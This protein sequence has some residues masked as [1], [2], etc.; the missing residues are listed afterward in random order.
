MV[1]RYE[2]LV[3]GHSNGVSALAAGMKALPR[4]D[5][6][7]AQT[8]A[9]WRFLNNE[10]VQPADL[11]KPLLAV[12][13]EGC[14]ESCAA[15]LLV[16]HDWSR[17][18]YRQH[19]S[20][21]DR[22]QMSHHY[23]V[24]YELQSSLLVADRDGAPICSPAQNLSTGEGVLSSCT[25]GLQPHAPHLDELTQRI[26][27]L[28]Q[29]QFDKP[30]VHIVD[31]EGDSVAHLRQWH[32]ADRGWLVRVKAGSRV[33]HD[34]RVQPVQ[35]VAAGLCFAAARQVEYQGKPAMQW[36]AETPGEL[37]RMAK[38]KRQDAAGRRVAPQAG[39]ALPA[40]L[41]V[42]R[43][44][45]E[46]G[47]V[48]AEWYLLSNVPEV[49]AERLALWYYW[50]WRIESY[51]KLLKG[52]GQQIE[53]WQQESGP[54][55]FKRLLIASQ[56]CALAWRLM[57][58]EGEVAEQTRTF[59]VRLAGRQMKRKRPVTAPALLEGLY[60]LLA[61]CDTLEQYTPAELTA[62]AQQAL[63]AGRGRGLGDV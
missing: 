32:A 1:R 48:L 54:A 39:A 14:R 61:M 59:L 2:L 33:C 45:G 24:G 8:Q 37:S 10:R 42:S 36:L 52:A 19:A 31:R 16:M 22:L 23:D 38:P 4:G 7:F 63:G 6:A 18:N 12:A 46:T 56:A 41:V 49:A 25:P 58:A 29:Q 44:L 51:F 43:I 53:Q 5:K 50:R 9:L 55:L 30:L 40:R 57:R 3:K 15:Y 26:D 11:V 27:W 20:K 17:L 21:T 60:L 62:F 13:H 34:N 35:A 28:E 47:Q